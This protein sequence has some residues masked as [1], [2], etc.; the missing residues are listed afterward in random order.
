M[1]PPAPDIQD[2]IPHA[3]RMVLLD[4]VVEYDPESIHCRAE[5]GDPADHPLAIDKQLPATVLAEYGAQAMAVHGGLL[6]RADYGSDTE[7]RPGRVAGIASL[8]LAVDH[9]TGHR[10]IDVHARC[11]GGDASG[12]IYDFEVL[13]ERRLLARGRIT[14]MFA[15][16]FDD[17]RTERDDRRPA[18]Q[19]P[20]R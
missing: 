17:K 10:S 4:E 12:R 13:D 19:G 16:V 1:S 14:I 9:V 11:Y 2:L 18:H 5:I 15:D 6:A 20:H 3:G 7:P 8:E